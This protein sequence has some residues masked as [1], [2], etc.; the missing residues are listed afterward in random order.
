MNLLRHDPPCDDPECLPCYNDALDQELHHGLND[1]LD[2]LRAHRAHQP[3]NPAGDL[4]QLAVHLCIQM[5][6]LLN[7]L[8]AAIRALTCALSHAFSRLFQSDA[9]L[10]RLHRIK[11]RYHR[12]YRRR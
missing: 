1:T 8:A 3:T 9:D 6:P 5:Q 2:H 7:Q 11:T 4:S 10:A 12:R